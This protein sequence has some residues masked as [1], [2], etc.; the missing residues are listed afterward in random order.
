M[1]VQDKGDDRL[2]ITTL[3]FRSMQKRLYLSTK[4][5]QD[6][7]ERFVNAR[8]QIDNVGDACSSFKEFLS[9]AVDV[10]VSCGFMQVRK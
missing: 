5:D 8:R 10:F 6:A 1:S 9:K 3:E 2:F 4:A 7:D